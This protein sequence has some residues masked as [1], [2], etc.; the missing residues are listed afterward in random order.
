MTSLSDQELG[1]AIVGCGVISHSHAPALRRV[2]GTR[3]VAVADIVPEKARQLGTEFSV[4]YSSDPR[5]VIE[6][7]D[8]D[9]VCVCVP[10][11]LH[12][13]IGIMAAAA[14]KH[15]VVEKPIDVSL[16]AA[17]RLI[18]ACDRAGIR[19]A[20]IS[21]LRF[22]DRVR[23]VRRL[24]DEGRL[25]RLLLG[26]AAV[27]W[28]RSQ[29]YYDAGGWRGTLALDGGGALINQAIHYLDLLQWMMGP[30]ESVVAR[31]GTTALHDIEGEDIALAILR[32]TGGGLGVVQASTA[33]YPG[34]AE[35]LELTGTGGTVVV[36]GG[37]I[38][39]R[40]LTEESGEAPAYGSRAKRSAPP[41]ETAAADPAAIQHEGHR[42][43]LTDFVEAVREGRAPFV[44]GP[45]GRRALETIHAI[46]RS[47]RTGQT[48]ELQ[49]A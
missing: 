30:V 11:G 34:L 21:Q 7:D 24:I 25:G 37:Q 1:F 19:L 49:T 22:N 28:Y 16:E 48:V 43:Q 23:E 15:V 32:F 36:E 12:A 41:A 10:S 20:V 9:A 38:A 26:E 27:K 29:A 33:V 31:T 44:G 42:R 47:A 46:Y 35:R 4:P 39:V 40:A 6:R 14:G 8:V 18:D 3:L 17:D 2:P 45:E 13:E 5:E